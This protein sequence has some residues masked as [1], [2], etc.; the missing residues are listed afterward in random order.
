MYYTLANKLVVASSGTVFSQAIS[1]DG[2][3][4]VQVE[5]TGLNVSATGTV[6]LTA[7]E[8]N[9]LENWSNLTTPSGTTVSTNATPYNTFKVASIASR[10]VRVQFVCNGFGPA[11]IAAGINTASL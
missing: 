4:A 1:M 2:A 5:F 8:G 6:T 11:V 3:N 10:Y 7:Q 9:D